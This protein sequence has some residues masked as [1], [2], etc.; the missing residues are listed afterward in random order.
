M[1]P[2]RSRSSPGAPDELGGTRGPARGRDHR[3]VVTLASPRRDRAPAGLRPPLVGGHQRRLGAAR[4]PGHGRA[5]LGRG[6]LPR[7]VTG[8]PGRHPACRPRRASRPAAGAAHVVEHHAGTGRDDVPARHDRRRHGRARRGHRLRLRGRAPDRAPRQ[9]LRDQPRCGRVPSEGGHRTARL[10]RPGAVRRGVRRHRAA[11][12]RP[13]TLRPHR[14]HDVGLSRP[15]QLAGR[16]S[17]RRSTR[18]DPR[19]NRAAGHRQPDTGRR[20]R[21]PYRVGPRRIHGG[22]HC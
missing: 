8:H 14:V 22:P 17:A 13:R 19:R 11:P 16:A 18:H 4:R 20:R 3:A 2:C 12:R 7:Q 1:T 9:R 21:R 5:Q 15:G 10:D 6:R